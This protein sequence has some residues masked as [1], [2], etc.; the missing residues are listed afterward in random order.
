MYM[1]TCIYIHVYI[2]IYIYIYIYMHVHYIVRYFTQVCVA[3]YDA[4]MYIKYLHVGE[5]SSIYTD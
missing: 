3:F 1:Y 5:F 4:Y 2:Y